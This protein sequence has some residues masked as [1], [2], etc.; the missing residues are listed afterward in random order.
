MVVEGP[1]SGV[2]VV[3]EDHR[4]GADP[5]QQGRQELMRE[6][7]N[8][9]LLTKTKKKKPPVSRRDSSQE[10]CENGEFVNLICNITTS[11]LR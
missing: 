5:G 4:E 8:P 9:T 6:K 7:T 3:E 1:H 2:E 10:E 11:Q